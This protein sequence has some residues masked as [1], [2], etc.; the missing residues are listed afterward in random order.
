MRKNN[1]G[2]GE[3]TRRAFTLIELLV[4]IAIIAVLIALLLPAVQ[5]ARE[6]A[7]RANCV[8][9]LKQF[10]LALH[11]YH[12]IN[13]SFPIGVSLNVATG[14]T[15][16]FSAQTRLLLFMEQAA[17][18]N[19]INF[20]RAT[21]APENATALVTSVNIF[22][23]PSDAQNQLPAGYAG[24]GYRVN[25]GTSIV[26]SFGAQDTAGVNKSMPPPN[27]LIFGDINI[28]V[29]DVID[30]TSNTA[31]FS[32]HV[33]GDYSN[34]ITT[35]LSDTYQ[36]GTYPADADEAL[37]MCRAVD[38]NDLTKQGNSNAGAPWMSDG[39]TTTKYYHGSPPNSRSC[40][41]P[42]QRTSTTAN[43]RHPGGVNVCIADGSVKFIKSSVNLVTWR[44]L[45]TRN[46]GEIISSDSF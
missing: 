2:L 35:E 15:S 42:P 20:S 31:A 9:N 21:S 27:G 10:G 7:R 45:G 22:L 16:T 30:G 41:F 39:H 44:A 46:G 29:A 25:C 18:Y 34:T 3:L 19:A 11:S 5:A 4:V 38:I 23:C 12:D 17:L 40:M 43:S 1:R 6:A 28:K 36:P 37:Q 33:K 14:S 13:G 26:N 24:I 32:E 8:S